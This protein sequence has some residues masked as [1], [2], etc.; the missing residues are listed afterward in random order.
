MSSVRSIRQ[1]AARRQEARQR[2][3]TLIELVIVLTILVALG[4]L[5]V[6]LA[7]DMLARTHMAKCS[8]TIP[9]IT[10]LLNTR[11]A[12]T[13]KLPNN[14]DSL[15]SNDQLAVFDG[16]PGGGDMSGQATLFSATADDIAALQNVGITSVIDA[17]G[18]AADLD[19]VT[20]DSFPPGTSPRVLSATAPDGNLVQLTAGDVEAAFFLP[21]GFASNYILFGLGNSASI[22]GP[23]KAIQE[24]PTHFGDTAEFNP[25][26]VYQRYGVVVGIQDAGTAD[27][28]A[29]LIGGC[30]IHG[31]GI[32]NAEEHRKEFWELSQ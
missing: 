17:A 8:V 9:E 22:V 18:A 30:A 10:K 13:L 29:V 23:G 24:A 3:L 4:S 28:A 11:Y 31:G 7:S 5:L 12:A 25:A 14:M 21:A 6:P 19:D 32:E 20:I 15:M 27:A 16:L 2:G 26:D 1:T